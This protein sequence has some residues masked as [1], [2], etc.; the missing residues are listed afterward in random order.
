MERCS[1]FNSSSQ[2]SHSFNSVNWKSIPISCDS[3][4]ES[5]LIL[6]NPLSS[7]LNRNG[8]VFFVVAIKC[9]I[10]IGDCDAIASR[11][12]YHRFLLCHRSNVAMRLAWSRNRN[13]KYFNRPPLKP[14][15]TGTVFPQTTRQQC[16]KSQLLLLWPD[17]IVK[18]RTRPLLQGRFDCLSHVQMD[19]YPKPKSGRD[20]ILS[21]R[22]VKSSR[23]HLMTSGLHFCNAKS[24]NA[25][26]LISFW[27]SGSR[28][29]DLISC[30]CNVFTL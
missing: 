8:K 18:F 21:T 19:P 29:K 23:A 11:I 25:F 15:S 28:T 13:R 9:L 4:Q 22:F 5:S 30:I 27:S 2:L 17:C 16:I 10:D 6:I 12:C 7:I 1:F 20:V 24:L 26:W 14:S 3:Y